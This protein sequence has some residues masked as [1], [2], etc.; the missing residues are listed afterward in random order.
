MALATCLSCARLS[1]V[2]ISTAGQA[3]PA[4]L[5]GS[6]QARTTLLGLGSLVCLS[7]RPQLS[8]SAP[9]CVPFAAIELAAAAPAVVS[10]AASADH[11]AGGSSCVGGSRSP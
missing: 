6:M 4:L 2:A 11:H 1:M 7:P 8:F 3:N 5:R 10:A 9:G